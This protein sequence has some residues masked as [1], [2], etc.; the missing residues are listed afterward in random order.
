M[1]DANV[2]ET[3]KNV[4]QPIW[5]NRRISVKEIFVV[6]NIRSIETIVHDK[7]KFIKQQQKRLQICREFQISSDNNDDDFLPQMIIA[8]G[9]IIFQ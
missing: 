3:F 9:I 5:N 1:V 8:E 2:L 7:L 6:L 4:D